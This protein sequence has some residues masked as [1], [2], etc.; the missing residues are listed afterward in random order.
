MYEL[1]ADFEDDRG[2]L[3]KEA[4]YR[5]HTLKIFNKRRED[6]SSEHD[7]DDYLEEVEDIVFKLANDIDVEETKARVE[8]YR[9]KN[10]DLI[11]QNQALRSEDERKAAESL[12]RCERDRVARLSALRKSDAEREEEARRMRR[13]LEREELQ[14]AS[15][16][17]EEA[18]RLKRKKD[19]RLEKQQRA[20]QKQAAVEATLHSKAPAVDTKP[21]FCRPA[22]PNPQ[23]SAVEDD[24]LLLGLK[25]S[26]S[27]RGS[28][29]G[30]RES[31]EL[32]RALLEFSE[33]LLFE[34]NQ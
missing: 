28:A 10:Q 18:A 16:G 19:R 4:R 27:T 8:S 12:A 31:T 14:R 22:F 32:H 5:R 24:C 23:P 21:M 20:L 1:S 11:G 6:F 7:Y 29:G 9:R 33:A 15:L 2:S 13:E 17:K 25:V 3:N 34:A 26:R 30:W